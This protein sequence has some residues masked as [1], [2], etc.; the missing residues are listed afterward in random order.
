VPRADRTFSSNDLIRIFTSHLEESERS[1]VKSSICTE[2]TEIGIQ[3]AVGRFAQI[4]IAIFELIP[5]V[6]DL[7]DIAKAL[8]TLFGTELPDVRKLREGM[9]LMRN[10]FDRT[11]DRSKQGIRSLDFDPEEFIDF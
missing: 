6:S 7:D 9:Q 3:V 1:D 2:T 11:I 5:L 10:E 8:N 4:A